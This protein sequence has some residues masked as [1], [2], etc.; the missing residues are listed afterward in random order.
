MGSNEKEFRLE[1][2]VYYPKGRRQ[3]ALR[4]RNLLFDRFDAF[5]SDREATLFSFG[6][7]DGDGVGFF[8]RAEVRFDERLLAERV[9]GVAREYSDLTI[10]CERTEGGVETWAH[11]AGPCTREL[12]LAAV[13]REWKRIDARLDDRPEA[14]LWGIRLALQKLFSK[15]R[16]PLD[17]EGVSVVKDETVFGGERL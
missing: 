4:A 17:G 11:T 9:S 7:I 14:S 3:E 5:P 10:R 12:A 13:R 15:D 1:C 16:A 6:Y 2:R 8:F